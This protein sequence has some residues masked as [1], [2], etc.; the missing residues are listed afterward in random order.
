[1]PGKFITIEGPDNVGKSTIIDQM[2]R[3]SNKLK[4]PF[5]NA[6]FIF[7]PGSTGTGKE[8][9]QITKYRED[10]NVDDYTCQLLMSADMASCAHEI[11]IPKIND[12]EN[13]VTD[14]LPMVSGMVY[15][16]AAGMSTSKIEAF[17]DAAIA[18]GVPKTHLIIL[19]ADFDVLAKRG[20]EPGFDRFESRD[21]EYKREV[22]KLY[23]YIA[24]GD[25]APA[26]A[27]FI[28]NRLDK[29][30]CRL[31]SDTLGLKEGDRSIWVVDASQPVFVVLGEVFRIVSALT[32]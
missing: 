15:G 3:A 1:M 7:T 16:Y 8:L 20:R 22:N 4:E 9:R 32:S 29:F 2:K 19:Y 26:D 18:S 30:V 14:R 27:S 17:Q 6:E 23:S 21:D 25:N 11:I 12:G 5:F 28:I 10:L 31:D 13:V 24:H